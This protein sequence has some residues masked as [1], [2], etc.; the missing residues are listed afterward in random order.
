MSKWYLGSAQVWL[1]GWRSVFGVAECLSST[2]QGSFD[3]SAVALLPAHL[4][5]LE[6]QLT[7]L[8][9]SFAAHIIHACHLLC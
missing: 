3:L 4:F 7:F 2:A 8:L 6:V 1:K 5:R 9:L